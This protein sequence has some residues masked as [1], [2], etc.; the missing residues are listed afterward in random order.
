MINTDVLNDGLSPLTHVVVAGILC[1][2]L[3]LLWY[4]SWGVSCETPVYLLD[5]CC[6][7]PPDELRIP[8]ATLIEQARSCVS[9]KDPRS[10]DFYAKSAERSGIGGEACAPP[11]M[12]RLPPDFSLKPSREETETVLFSV[13]K[14][15]LEKNGVRPERV[16][17]LVS[18]CSLF[19]PTPSITSMII[20]KFGMRSN[21]KS[22]S[23]SGMGC[24]AGV[25][26]VSVAK[27]L[28]KVHR[29]SVALVVSMEAIT[30][31][32]YLGNDKSMILTNTLFRMGGA[33]VLLSNHRTRRRRPKYKLQHL[34]RTHFGA[35]DASYHS[36]FQNNDDFGHQGVHLSR[37][38][39]QVAGRALKSNIS[40]LGPRVLPLSELILYGFATLSRKVFGKRETFVPNF[41][42][43]FEHFC[44]HAGGR[45]VI[46]AVQ[47]SL[48]LSK[49][50]V[51]AS[52]M[53]LYRFGNTSSSSIWYELSYL[54]AKGRIKKGERV[55]QI[56]F[57]SGFKCNSAVWVCI[58]QLRPNPT[59]AWSDRINRYPVQVPKVLDH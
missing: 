48:K 4:V 26:S 22:Y 58:S 30:P 56:A 45:A 29:K 40:E 34:V 2:L 13:V 15:V 41:N 39:L 19:C 20:N 46:D 36:V 1:V 8:T 25:V 9:V 5:F 49:E 57:G 3:L 50:D 7:R 42:K 33:A 35:D 24:S 11:A 16:D 59:N 21:V 47:D 38:L 10:L 32:G 28:L 55:W 51:E 14:D 53:T 23:L 52:R 12:H 27:D 31:N 43:A 6:Y 44:I 37:D 17:I 54:E 18:N